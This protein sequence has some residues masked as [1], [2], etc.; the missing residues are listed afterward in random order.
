MH[1]IKVETLYPTQ[2]TYMGGNM[3]KDEASTRV[4]RKI[5]FAIHSA[6]L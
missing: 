6:L 2:N 5:C 4:I 1:A 3:K